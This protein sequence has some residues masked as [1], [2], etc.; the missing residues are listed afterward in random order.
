MTLFGCPFCFWAIPSY[1]YLA[2]RSLK[3]YLLLFL[4][5]EEFP[6]SLVASVRPVLAP[7]RH[8]ILPMGSVR[9][10]DLLS[11]FFFLSCPLSVEVFTA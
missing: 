11:A 3:L 5:S 8:A 9:P 1:S 7:V 4:A 2:K 10:V 6:G